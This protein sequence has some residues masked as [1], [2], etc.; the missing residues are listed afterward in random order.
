M[1]KEQRKERILW[2]RNR[3]DEL[4]QQFN[5]LQAEQ[6][7]IFKGFEQLFERGNQHIEEDDAEK[8]ADQSKAMHEDYYALKAKLDINVKKVDDIEAEL[9]WLIEEIEKVPRD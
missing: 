1:D 4:E 3:N 6:N 9:D 2:I 5:E 8:L 7:E